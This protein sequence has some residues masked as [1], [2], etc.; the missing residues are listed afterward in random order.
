M[1]I[2][3]YA[4]SKKIAAHAL[5]GVQ[6]MSVNGQTLIINTKDSGILTMTFPTPKDG[7][8]VTDIDVNANNQIVFTMSDGTEFISGEIPTIKGDAGFSPTI[9]ENKN[10]TDKIYK[11]DITTADSTFTTPNL[12]GTG[13]SGEENVIDS[14]S[15][16]GVNVAPDENKN[17]DITVPD[18]YDDTA[19]AQRVT[20][21]ELDYAKSS[22]IPSLSG[23]ATET[24][25]N[26]KLKT[27]KDY[28]TPKMFGAVGDGITDDTVSLQAAITY[29]ENNGLLLFLPKGNYIFSDRLFI[30]K[31]ITI[32]GSS[33]D[34]TTLSFIGGRDKVETTHYGETW[35]EEGDSAI[36]I[37]SNNVKLSGFKL[38]GVVNNTNTTFNGICMHWTHLKDPNDD[39]DRNCYYGA[40]R[41]QIEHV[42]IQGFRNN[43]FIFAGW[44]RYFINCYFADATDSGIK[45]L[46]L[47]PEYTGKWACSGDMYMSCGFNNC[48]V[49]GFYAHGCFQTSLYNGI[50]EF[51]QSA[52]KCINCENIQFYNCWNEANNDSIYIEGNARFIGGYNISKDTINHTNGYCTVELDLDMITF[53]GDKIIFHKQNG[54]ITK[55]V[56]IGLELENL[57]KNSEFYE[58]SQ[59][60]LKIPS[61]SGWTKYVDWSSSVSSDVLYNNNYTVLFD[62]QNRDDNP[63]FNISQEL[64]VPSGK[65]IVSCMVMAPDKSTVDN[66]FNVGIIYYNSENE[67]IDWN[68]YI[69]FIVGNNSWEKV[70]TEYEVPS[71]VSKIAVKFGPKNNGICYMANP[72]VSSSDDSEKNNVYI[73]KN[74]ES[75]NKVNLYDI[76]GSTL[77][78][79]VIADEITD[80]EIDAIINGTY[81]E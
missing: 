19:L 64:I 26:E 42:L 33:L 43:V 1:D 80:D 61:L 3:T 48:G 74:E 14:I 41:V 57:L 75:E 69:Y 31:P 46:P 29:A 12:K 2:I 16:N 25:V 56:N 4:L 77:G 76:N 36:C 50:F 22:D 9:I 6:S 39:N 5:S 53:Q 54:I 52:I 60:V 23:Y 65:Y 17:V 34:T 45:Y 20:D 55:G 24:W 35:W 51:N 28:V 58:N 32:M 13:G 40:E 81:V 68:N 18:A 11:L 59:G 79:I 67:V 66:G 71:N 7:V 30:R 63:E 78:T 70:S 8:S 47:E 37:Q 21:I 44:D 72:C 38:Y 27:I 10:N 73:R 62:I 15:V 49:A